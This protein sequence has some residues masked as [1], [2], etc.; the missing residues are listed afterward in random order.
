MSVAMVLGCLT[1][2]QYQELCPLA[3]DLSAL[4]TVGV[5]EIS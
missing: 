3:G 1:Y 2:C 4:H 5:E